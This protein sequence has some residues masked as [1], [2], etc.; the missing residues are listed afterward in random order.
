[1]T[2]HAQMWGAVRAVGGARGERAQ[3]LAGAR[4]LA[5]CFGSAR[6][7]ALPRLDAEQ[8]KAADGASTRL[9][10]ACRDLAA[11]AKANAWESARDHLATVNATFTGAIE[12]A[13]A[14]PRFLSSPP[15][16]ERVLSKS[17]REQDSEAVLEVLDAMMA[18]FASRSP[19]SPTRREGGM[20]WLAGLVEMSTDTDTKW[21]L[22]AELT[23]AQSALAAL[24]AEDR[25][26]CE[27]DHLDPRE[28]MLGALRPQLTK[29]ATRG[30]SPTTPRNPSKHISVV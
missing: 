17:I 5:L 30:H 11:T 28:V 8:V 27:L 22:A 20:D 4:A 15:S 29:T 12:L 3:R 26:R 19:V 23:D 16:F 13:G 24:S 9:W 1:M 10:M 14:R 25:E 2:L 18:I 21:R 6:E 7:R